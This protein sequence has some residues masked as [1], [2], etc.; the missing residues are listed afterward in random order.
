MTL[1]AD[2]PPG[3]VPP[4]LRAE[5]AHGEALL[6]MATGD[7]ITARARFDAAI[8]ELTRLGYPYWLARVQTDLAAVLIDEDRSGEAR[9]LLDDAI[10]ALRRLRA[11][12]ALGRADA[13]LSGLPVAARG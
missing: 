9:P 11:T 12:P 8:E 7:L 6:A 10:A 13:L 2:V 5:R 1:L 4:F 3:H